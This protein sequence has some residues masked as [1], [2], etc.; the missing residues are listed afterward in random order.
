M[1]IKDSRT[2]VDA[3]KTLLNGLPNVIVV[4]AD[5]RLAN[6]VH[7]SFDHTQGNTQQPQDKGE[8]A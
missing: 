3:L 2:T 4:K 8:Q 6:G 7:I 5:I 1:V